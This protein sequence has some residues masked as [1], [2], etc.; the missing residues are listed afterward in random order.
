MKVLAYGEIMDGGASVFSSVAKRDGKKLIMTFSGVIRIDYPYKHLQ[1][2][3]ADLERLI[4]EENLESVEFDFRELSFCNSNGFYIIMD[5]TELIIAQVD[6]PVFVKRLEDDDWQ[7][8]TL[9]ILLNVD[10]P[11]I[12]E[13]VVFEDLPEI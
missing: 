6:G 1:G 11:D 12:G 2:Y 7:Q 9:P 8:E 13:R 10:E 3:I 5:I 4:P